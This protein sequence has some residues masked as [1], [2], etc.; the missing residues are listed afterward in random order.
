MV[1]EGKKAGKTAQDLQERIAIET[2]TSLQSNGHGRFLE[3]NRDDIF[4]P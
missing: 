3:S 4:A 2:M 1:E